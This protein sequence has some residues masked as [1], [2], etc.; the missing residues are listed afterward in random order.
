VC[1]SGRYPKPTYQLTTFHPNVG[2][3]AAFVAAGG[4]G[5]GFS[6]LVPLA[7][8]G[9]PP[10][11]SMTRKISPLLAG[12]A[13]SR[14]A[15]RIM[16]SGCRRSANEQ[17]LSPPS[18]ARVFQEAPLSF[19]LKPRL[20]PVPSA[21]AVPLPGTVATPA[22]TTFSVERPLVWRQVWVPSV[23]TTVPP[24]FT[25]SA[26]PRPPKSGPAG[27]KSGVSARPCGSG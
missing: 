4:P 10:A 15:K 26:R 25:S 8:S 12:P 11:G 17:S 20:S 14:G 9:G 18:Y 7:V 3:P 19:V 23:D 16:R 27:A 5:I 1:T 2:W 6:W 22:L 13:L 21:I 24:S